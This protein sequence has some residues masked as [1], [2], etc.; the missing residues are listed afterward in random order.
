MLWIDDLSK[1]DPFFILPILMGAAMLF[2][3][4]LSPAPPD[5]VQARVM[6]IMPIIFTVMFALFPAG[7]VVYWL[8]NTVLSIL[9]Q[10]RINTLVA[11]EG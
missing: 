5:P 6:Q 4:R 2:Q 7:L 10:W 8:T 9:Q 1:R 11:R 3:T